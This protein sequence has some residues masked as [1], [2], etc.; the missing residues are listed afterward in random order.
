MIEGDL[1]SFQV[2]EARPVMPTVLVRARP[3]DT[4]GRPCV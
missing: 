2:A 3:E 1:W 4:A